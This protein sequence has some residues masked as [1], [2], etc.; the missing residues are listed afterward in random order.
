MRDYLDPAGNFGG[1]LKTAPYSFADEITGGQNVSVS[2]EATVNVPV[3]V[4]VT[5][6]SEL[7]SIINA[8]RDVIK[9]AQMALNPV[10]GGH[11]GRMDSDA[12]PLGAGGIGH[13]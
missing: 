13:R 8:A 11:S 2:G 6:S 1:R 4:E 9:S 10:A 12:A 3:K 7:L 5:A